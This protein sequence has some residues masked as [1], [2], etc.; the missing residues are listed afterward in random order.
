MTRSLILLLILI[1]AHSSYS[2]EPGKGE[3]PLKYFDSGVLF[4]ERVFPACSDYNAAGVPNYN[5]VGMEGEFLS[6]KLGKW[7]WRQRLSGDIGGRKSEDLIS[8]ILFEGDYKGGFSVWSNRFSVSLGTVVS[9]QPTP[10]LEIGLPIMFCTRMT[11]EVGSYYLYEGQTIDPND[12]ASTSEVNKSNKV[13]INRKWMPGLK[14][15][16]E[17]VAFPNSALSLLCRVNYQ[18]FGWRDVYDVSTAKLNPVNNEITVDHDRVWSTPEWGITIGLKY[19]FY[20]VSKSVQSNRTK[21]E[22]NPKVILT[23][24]KRQ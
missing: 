14:T 24:K 1:G 6:L 7:N 11:S 19:Y 13:V 18:Y 4:F 17:L 5:V 20:K 23:P 2:Q 16:L 9:F 15:G 3:R 22:D 12:V 10:K 21:K 8:N